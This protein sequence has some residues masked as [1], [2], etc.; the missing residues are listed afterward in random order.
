MSRVNA[1]RLER[2]SERRLARRVCVTACAVK[3][4]E[5]VHWIVWR[6]G[7]YSVLRYVVAKPENG[8]LGDQPQDSTKE[9]QD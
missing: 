2:E 4:R 5:S 7:A 8:L 9:L 1:S 6:T 3:E